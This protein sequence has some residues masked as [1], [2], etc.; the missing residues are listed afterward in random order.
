M[1][2]FFFTDGFYF[3]IDVSEFTFVNSASFGDT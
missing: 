1:T 3:S 2:H